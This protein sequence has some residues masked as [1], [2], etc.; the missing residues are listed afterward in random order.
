MAYLQV[1]TGN[2]K[3][4]TTA[5]LGL[6][7]RAVCAGQKVHMLQFIKGMDYSELEAGTYLPGFTIEQMGRDC[8][9]RNEPTELDRKLAKDGME[10]VR[11]CLQDPSIDVLILDEVNIALYYGL[12]ELPELLDAI[13]DRQS[14]EVI[15]TG[16]YAPKELMDAADL[17]TEMREIKHYYQKKVPARVGIEK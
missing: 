17:V 9:I 12:I 11:E 10:R 1:Y 13:R 15:C 2:G 5:A 4:K 8:F 6:A 7:L 16:R 3:G 14:M